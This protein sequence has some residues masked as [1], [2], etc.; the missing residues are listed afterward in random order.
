MCGILGIVNRSAQRRHSLSDSDLARIAHRGPDGSGVFT[1]E[2]VQLGHVRLSIIDLTDAGHQPM[3]SHEGRYVVTFNGEIYNY[4]ELKGELELLGER[5]IGHSDT[6][7]LL[8]AYKVWGTDCVKRFLGM[9]AFVIWDKNEHTVFIARDRCGEKP[10]FFYFDENRFV[11]GSELKAVIPLL[12]FTP[13]LNVSAVDKYLHYQ[14]VPEPDT[15]LEGIHKL[16]AGH[17]MVIGL[18]DWKVEPKRYWSVETTSYESNSYVSGLDPLT[19]IRDGLE[20]A[21]K[22]TLRS[23]V[24]VGIALSGGIDSGAIA[25]LAQRNYVQPM[26]AFCVG[27]P[28]RPKYDE[29]AQAKA[30][31]DS[32]GMIVHEVE[33]PTNNF[34][35]FFPELV[36]I[37][38]EPIADPAA[39]G[40]YSVPRAAA[41]QGIK[42]LLSGIGGDEIFWGYHWVT[43]SVRLNQLV[44]KHP[45]IQMLAC[46]ASSETAQ[47]FLI[48]VAGYPHAHKTIRHWA[49]ILQKVGDPHNADHQDIFYM[50]ALDF[51]DAFYVKKAIYG[52]SMQCLTKQML[53]K[54]TETQDR[55]IEK[56]P[57][58]AIRMLFDTWLVSNCLSLGDR[59]SMAV[60]VETRMP[61]LDAR[62]I[63][64]VMSL[65]LKNPDHELGQKEWLRTALKGIVP[66]EVLKR[67]K[68]GFQP[69]V[70]EWLS[71]VV[72]KYIEIIRDGQLV[73]S[74]VLA[75]DKIDFICKELPKQGWREMY[76]AY[77]LVLLEMWYQKIVAAS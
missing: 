6:E 43:Q 62:L 26:H 28:G 69:P 40:H 19:A 65:R 4:L 7:V 21:V 41:D 75:K 70:R 9:F 11:F 1:D 49:D 2:H 60:G 3:L 61:F 44:A 45:S 8:S 33:L 57:A 15:L 16:A 64:L 32:L 22:L 10:L 68:A 77:K 54:P 72:K 73:K 39:F 14:Y 58:H 56:I 53:Y 23:D 59:V 48:K 35:D 74:G 36:K 13:S 71:G 37:L 63:E 67:P 42:V 25:V 55:L 30:L 76:F 12:G 46:W 17:F 27:Y 51:R 29:R 5:F 66:D 52:P 47:Q 24:P 31:A 20:D 50:L 18:S 34:V 38:D